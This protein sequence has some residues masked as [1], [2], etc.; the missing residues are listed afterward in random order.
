MIRT[1]ILAFGLLALSSVHADI[2]PLHACTGTLQVKEGKG[3]YG[4]R[5][6]PRGRVHLELPPHSSQYKVENVLDL[7]V[8]AEVNLY[9]NHDITIIKNERMTQYVVEIVNRSK[10]HLAIT[11]AWSENARSIY[12]YYIFTTY[13]RTGESINGCV[14]LG[15]V[16]FYPTIQAQQFVPF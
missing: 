10:F 1:Y 5:Y 7:P 16:P 3:G 4:D 14:M 2:V 8:G 12:P 9:Y 13:A 11:L 15:D 6:D